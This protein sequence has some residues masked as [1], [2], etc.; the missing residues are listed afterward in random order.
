MWKLLGIEPT[1]D[2]RA[3]KKAYAARLKTIDP[4]RDPQ[5]FIAL[6][7]ARET[8]LYLA[9]V[10]HPVIPAFDEADAEPQV[11][12]AVEAETEP[13]T[14]TE[15]ETELPA[16][17][18]AS[19]APRVRT[20]PWE[21]RALDEHMQ[22]I[23]GMLFAPAGAPFDPEALRSELDTL[24][25]HPQMAQIGRADEV[26]DWLAQA[27]VDGIPRS[28]VL[29][30]PA[31]RRFDWAG[32]AEEWQCP[33]YVQN[34]VERYRDCLFRE[35]ARQG[36]HGSAMRML[37]KPPPRRT[38]I[39]S[40]WGVAH[41]LRHIRANHPTV[42][43]DFDAETIAWW[44][45]QLAERRRRFP[46]AKALALAMGLFVIER[47]SGPRDLIPAAS[48]AAAGAGALLWFALKRY[49]ERGIDEDGF[50]EAAP[51]SRAEGGA[52]A[53]LLLL[54]IAALLAPVSSIATIGF[55]L[56]AG[57]L[58]LLAGPVPPPEDENGADIAWQARIAILAPVLW[59][60]SCL[61]AE[62]AHMQALIPIAAAAW[63][64]F[65]HGERVRT[66]LFDGKRD[67]PV[68]GIMFL[69]A[70]ALWYHLAKALAAPGEHPLIPLLLLLATLLVV[71]HQLLDPP[72]R[73][74]KE[75][76]GASVLAIL[77]AALGGPLLATMFV[78]ARTGRAVVRMG[79]EG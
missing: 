73:W 66:V 60:H 51:L 63:A 50:L 35:K 29:I 30:G 15:T 71:V 39:L 34:V 43:Q 69:G 49:L 37:A 48:A 78:L 36:E 46:W 68:R 4:D 11:E 18:A 1:T 27:I 47:L 54:P 26:E 6:R 33:W 42:E 55:A 12:A 32:K 57:A 28:D 45:A 67:R 38:N 77:V 61:W 72:D 14:E 41:F 64:A 10:E 31:M 22:R 62:G 7:E 75:W 2:S 25:R 17:P 20:S 23:E 58:A 5:A 76:S 65:V 21:V 52:L 3:I 79:N 8:A 16:C 9:A 24:L 13:E 19:A 74:Q 53:G 56:A 59:L 44:D 40:A 70:F